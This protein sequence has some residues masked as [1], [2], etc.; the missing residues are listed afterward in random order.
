MAAREVTCVPVPCWSL[1]TVRS[2]MLG[3]RTVR[4]SPPLVNGTTTASPDTAVAQS[5]SIGSRQR[6]P[7]L[8]AGL[9]R[10]SPGARPRDN[11]RVEVALGTSRQDCPRP[12]AS[13]AE[14]PEWPGRH[15][16]PSGAFH[17]GGSSHPCG[18]RRAPVS[19]SIRVER[20]RPPGVTTRYRKSRVTWPP[21]TVIV[22][23]RGFR[24]L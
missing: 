9:S 6:K 17:P 11:R 3:K 4:P 24:P 15:H 21:V 10:R 5:R 19:R 22:G 23:F 20:H 8:A 18:F 16:R 7:L 1:G 14:T 2:H 12:T 13:P